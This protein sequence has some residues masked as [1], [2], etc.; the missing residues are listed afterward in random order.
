[1]KSLTKY[2]K[3]NTKHRIEFV[4]LTE[5]VARIVKESR[6]KEGLCLVNSMHITS[7]VFIND[8]RNKV[9]TAPF[10]ALYF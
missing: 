2:I 4:N 6:V 5:D 9:Q 1:M 7:S 8:V 10:R 3:I